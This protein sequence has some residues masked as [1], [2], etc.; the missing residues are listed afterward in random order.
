M[1]K[2]SRTELQM[3]R[4]RITPLFLRYALPGVLAMV[5]LALQTIADG[6]IV[7]RLIGADALAAVNIAAPAY[8]V[9]TAVAMII[10]IGTQ[11]QLSINLGAG[12]YRDAKTAFVSGLAGVALFSLCGTLL[13]NLRAEQ[14]AS[15]LGA[16]EVLLADT[17]EYIHGV[18][19]WLMGIAAHI[20]FDNMLKAA[21]HPRFAMAITVSTIVMN[22]I[23]SLIFVTVFDMGTFGAGLGTGISFTCGGLASCIL[24][25]SKLNR[26]PSL[27]EAKGEFSLE[28][29][30]HIFYNGSSEGLSEF[31]YAVTTFLFNVTLMQY[32]GKEGVSAFTLISYLTY[33]GISIS[34]GV[35]TGLIPVISYNHGAG[36]DKRVRRIVNLALKTNMA[37][38]ALFLLVLFFLGRH[39][40]SIF[41]DP[42]DV[43]VMEYAVQGARF[44]AFA[45]LFNG[46]NILASSYF[47]AIDKAGYSL[48]VASLRGLL[49]LSV[50]IILLPKLLG[51]EGIMLAMPIAEAITFVTALAVM[52]KYVYRKS[53]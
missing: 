33:L 15:A 12:N 44:T 46:F 6:F 28:S 17:V 19:P 35:S 51:F 49:I 18:M 20:F 11:A 9:V 26:I 53:S 34:L 38:G 22:V 40:C 41:I 1:Q 25:F 27:K 24:F 5:F 36:N 21:G 42:S 45:F 3:A 31:A 2:I 43:K 39:I 4:G 10:G 50:C 23:L 29:L 8:S 13:V 37:C 48:L 16:D 7:G 52:R 47:T 14:L 32:V 30:G